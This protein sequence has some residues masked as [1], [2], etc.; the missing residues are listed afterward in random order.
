MQNKDTSGSLSFSLSAGAD[1]DFSLFVLYNIQPG[2]GAFLCKQ[3]QTV[4][5]NVCPVTFP[6][7]FISWTVTRR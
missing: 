1:I 3:T 4:K 2:L 6:R 5:Q 7:E